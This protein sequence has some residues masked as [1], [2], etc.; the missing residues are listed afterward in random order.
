MSEVA[1][2]ASVLDIT[3]AKISTPVL[4][5]GLSIGPEIDT[6]NLGLCMEDGGV[7]Y[8]HIDSC[9][10]TFTGRYRLVKQSIISMELSM[11]TDRPTWN[12]RRW[13]NKS[14]TRLRSDGGTLRER[15]TIMRL[16]PLTR[17]SKSEFS[18]GAE[19]FRNIL[20][21]NSP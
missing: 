8:R 7:M 14:R 1:S 10:N 20:Q 12:L 6:S 4:P 5:D 11:T 19:C 9:G 21:D 3:T 2:G 13:Q 18:I 17:W 15:T 16:L